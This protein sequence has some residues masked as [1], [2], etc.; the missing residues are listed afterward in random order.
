MLKTIA[1]KTNCFNE[2]KAM[3]YFPLGITEEQLAELDA[4]IQDHLEED[5]YFSDDEGIDYILL[6]DDACEELCLRCV[7]N[8]CDDEIII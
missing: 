8:G 6:I 7:I 1:V 5:K 3:L 4:Y 2:L